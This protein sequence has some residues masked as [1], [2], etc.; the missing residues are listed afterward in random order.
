[1]KRHKLFI[2]EAI[3][4]PGGHRGELGGGD[5]ATTGGLWVPFHKVLESGLLVP[6]FRLCLGPL[7]LLSFLLAGLAGE[8]TLQ[9]FGHPTQLLS[10]RPMPTLARVLAEV[11]QLQGFQSFSTRIED[12]LHSVRNGIEGVVYVVE[13]L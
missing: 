11:A 1:M 3:S 7:L 9:C 12:W 4:S 5:S 13:S 6:L 8:E 2:G 10:D